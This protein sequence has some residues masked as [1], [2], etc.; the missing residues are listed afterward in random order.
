MDE[1]GAAR[2]QGLKASEHPM[3]P[4]LGGFVTKGDK[5]MG[6]GQWFPLLKVSFLILK[7]T[8]L[9]CLWGK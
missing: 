7:G 4:L 6:L 8:F 3:E 1:S 9:G 2:F 5:E